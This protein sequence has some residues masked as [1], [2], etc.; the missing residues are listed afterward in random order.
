MYKACGKSEAR[1][2]REEKE[3]KRGVFD[4]SSIA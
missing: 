1:I 3:K 4:F 2:Y